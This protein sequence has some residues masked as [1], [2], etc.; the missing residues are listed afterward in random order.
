MHTLFAVRHCA[1]LTPGWLPASV[2]LLARYAVEADVWACG[3]WLVALLVGAF[4]FDNRPGVDD[5]TAE[6]QIL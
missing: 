5:I 3:I 1:A 6:L 4:P 2:A